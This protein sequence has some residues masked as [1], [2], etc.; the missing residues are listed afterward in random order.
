[1]CV[2][3][4]ACYR[5]SLAEVQSCRRRGVRMYEAG[6][7][8]CCW[9]YVRWCCVRQDMLRQCSLSLSLSLSLS[10][11]RSSSSSL[12]VSLSLRRPGDWN[13]YCLLHQCTH[14]RTLPSSRLSP[15]AVSAAGSSWQG[16]MSIGG[17]FVVCLP[18]KRM[19]VLRPIPAADEPPACDCLGMRHD[20]PIILA[21]PC[22]RHHCSH[23]RLPGRLAIKW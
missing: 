8:L 12:N 2:L 10:P 1:M 9:L 18:C 16:A 4:P 13:Y 11:L 20:P 3:G 5:G 7:V 22:H 23:A 14:A 21:V 19:R 17:L 15:D 6:V